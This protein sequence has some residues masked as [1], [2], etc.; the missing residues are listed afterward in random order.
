MTRPL[1]FAAWAETSDLEGLA[2]LER[3][4]FTHPWSARSFREVLGDPRLGRIL[5][6]RSPGAGAPGGLLVGY[7]VFQVVADEVHVHDLAVAEAWRRQGVARALLEIALARAARGGAAAAFLEVRTGNLPAQALYRSAGFQT[8][9]LRKGYYS[10][11]PEDALVLRRNAL[12]GDP[13]EEEPPGGGTP[14][15]AVAAGSR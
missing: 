11:P 9:A 14:D 7:C 3:R 15:R 10:Q 6:A 8:V 2:G 4:S 12:V 1:L 13:A 5:V